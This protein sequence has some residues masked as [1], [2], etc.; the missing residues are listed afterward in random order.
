MLFIFKVLLLLLLETRMN[1]SSYFT[2]KDKERRHHFTQWKNEGKK[3]GRA[4]ELNT[5]LIPLTTGHGYLM[6]SKAR[7]L[8]HLE[9]GSQNYSSRENQKSALR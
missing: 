5:H 1:Q 4:E 9:E 2:V 8:F 3:L 6:T 7:A